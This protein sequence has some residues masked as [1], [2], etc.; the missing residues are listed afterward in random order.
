MNWFAEVGQ[1]IGYTP[2]G[3]TGHLLVL[4]ATDATGSGPTRLP[5]CPRSRSHLGSFCHRRRLGSQVHLIHDKL[6]VER[7]DCFFFEFVTRTT[8]ANLGIAV[9]IAGNICLVVDA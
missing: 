2:G 1:L 5:V 9:H 7:H 8:G 6:W 3:R 4:W